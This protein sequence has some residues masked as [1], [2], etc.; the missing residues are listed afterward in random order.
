MR[1]PVRSEGGLSP[2]WRVVGRRNEGVDSRGY[3]SAQV[4]SRISYCLA[5]ALR[6]LVEGAV[7]TV[8]GGWWCHR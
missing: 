6:F 7:G 4:D 5:T 1:R 2:R 8:W 3:E